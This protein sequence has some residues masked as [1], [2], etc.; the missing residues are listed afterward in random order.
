MNS[1]ERRAA[2]ALA[3]VYAVRMLGLFMILPV[4]ALYAEGLA[5]VTPSLVGLAIGVYGFTQA[6]LQLP[7]GMLSDRLGRKPV[8]VAGL[9]VFA[10]GSVVAAMSDSIYGVILGRALQGAGAVAAALMALAADLTREEQRTKAMAMIGASIGVAFTLALVLGPLLA[11]W[12]EVSGIFWVTAVL[13][14]GAIALVLWVVP[15]PPAARHHR[16]AQAT[17][18]QFRAVLSDPQL[19][20]LD[21]GILVLHLILTA[22]FVVIPLMLRDLGLV[23][24]GHH[25]RIYLPVIAA[26]F[27]L[28]LPF[29]LLAER[30]RKIKPVFVGAVGLL[31]AA[32]L[33]FVFGAASVASLAVSLFLFFVAFNLLEASLPSLVSKIAPPDRKGT[34]L[35]IYSTSQFF[36]IFLGGVLGGAAYGAAGVEAVFV[37]GAGLTLIWLGLAATMRRPRFLSSYLLKIGPVDAARARGLVAELTRVRGVAEAVVV[38]EEGVAYLKVE[39]HALDRERLREFSVNPA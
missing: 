31:A 32:E 16:D 2:L 6:A 24:V 27:L 29:L 5:G 22:N 23:E 14:L 9:L 12:V 18:T 19:L 15:R 10:I 1:G 39:R 38:A 28:M 8:I 21:F 4:F 37:G 17:P 30:R 20:R 3:G 26:S 33:S 34:A 35:G 25:W 13:A 7:L 11:S 36:G